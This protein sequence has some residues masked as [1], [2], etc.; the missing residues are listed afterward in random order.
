[1]FVRTYK[2]TLTYTYIGKYLQNLFQ[3]SI[4]SLYGMVLFV[5]LCV[6]WFQCTAFRLLFPTA[7]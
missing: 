6:F 2:L 3:A 4:N 7:L 5:L 1:M